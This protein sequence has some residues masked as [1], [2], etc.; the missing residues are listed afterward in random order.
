MNIE[1]ACIIGIGKYGHE[2]AKRLVEKGIS[3]SPVTK[4]DLFIVIY[5]IVGID[6]D[7]ETNGE[8]EKILDHIEIIKKENY[9]LRVFLIDIGTAD[10]YSYYNTHLAHIKW[11][12]FLRPADKN[13]SYNEISKLLSLHYSNIDIHGLL[14]FDTNDWVITIRGKRYF[15]VE[16]YDYTDSAK[17]ALEKFEFRT[18]SKT[19]TTTHPGIKMFLYLSSK[20]M[21]DIEKQAQSLSPVLNTLPEEYELRFNCGDAAKNSI[22]LLSSWNIQDEL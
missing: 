2:M 9:F 5:L 21:K 17:K 8:L 6:K 3:W 16:C 7:E 19:Y 10:I 11:Y 22:W 20:S 4:P 15:K 14:C 13:N 12:G 1:T 18:D